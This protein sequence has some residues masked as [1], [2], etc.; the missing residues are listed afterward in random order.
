MLNQKQRFG[1]A[2][3]MLSAIVIYAVATP[4]ASALTPRD[5]KYLQD[6][7]KTDRFLGGQYI[8][9]DHLCSPQEWSAMKQAIGS[10]QRNPGQCA[11]LKQWE[12]CTPANQLKSG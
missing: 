6:T 7:H 2:A 10:A 1:L 3:V 9:G 8:C 11:S 4:S 5:F 12:A